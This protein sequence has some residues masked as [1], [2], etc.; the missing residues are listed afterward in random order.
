VPIPVELH[1]ADNYD[2][3]YT[4]APVC[5][6]CNLVTDDEWVSPTFRLG[7]RRPDACFTRDGATIVSQRFVDAATGLPGA[8]YLPLPAEP[9]SFLMIINQ[10]LVP[11]P[12]A[13][14]AHFDAWCTVCERW[15]Q[16]HGTTRWFLG[17]DNLPLGFSQDIVAYGGAFGLPSRLSHPLFVHPASVAVLKAARLR[18][19]SFAP[20]RKPGDQPGDP[21]VGVMRRLHGCAKAAWI[22]KV[23][24]AADDFG[25]YA[26]HTFAAG[27]A[28]HAVAH[29]PSA[30]HRAYL[31]ITDG[32][33]LFDR[34]DHD[35]PTR[36]RGMQIFSVS[37]I[38][39]TSHFLQD[40]FRSA[41]A[42]HPDEFDDLCAESDIDLQDWYQGMT[43]VAVIVGSANL[44]VADQTELD[45]N[46][47]PAIIMLDHELFYSS[48]INDLAVVNRWTNFAEFF[49]DVV[50]NYVTYS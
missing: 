24:A 14:R 5:S 28:P 36:R 21:F 6:S 43:P 4:G 30:L 46:E 42:D 31:E 19:A 9:G 1:I 37:E 25:S 17:E 29:L 18:G 2:E 35:D 39:R 45:I 22:R 3:F 41:C 23:D 38:D 26:T 12:G 16:V 48:P 20:L 8:R 50:E 32:A 33:I 10:Q 13:H 40:T 49:E 44:I 15:T 11:D 34:A 47:E 7:A 27:A